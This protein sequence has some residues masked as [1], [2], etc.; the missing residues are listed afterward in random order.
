VST[1]GGPGGGYPEYD[2]GGDGGYSYPTGGYGYPGAPQ[3]GGSLQPHNLVLQPGRRG[4]VSRE[5]GGYWQCAN[6]LWRALA[7]L[8]DYGPLFLLYGIAAQIGQKLRES[9]YYGHEYAY[10]W[11]PVVENLTFL[12]CV[13]LAVGNSIVLQ[14]LTAQS[15]GK[16]VLG[17]QVIRGV[18]SPQNE[19]L[20]VRPGVLWAF[21]RMLAHI[22]DAIPCY[23]GFFAPIWTFQ[24]QTFSDKIVNTAVLKE[25][26]PIS[27]SFAPPGSRS[28]KI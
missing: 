5:G 13:L 18:V 1:Y 19:Q 26:R 24:Y 15:I 12:L 17:M 25:P 10:Q 6:W 7:G 20:I 27:L 11:A 2:Q 16:K 4:M 22:V 21:L 14:G 8:I 9:Y 3:T 28:S 23:I